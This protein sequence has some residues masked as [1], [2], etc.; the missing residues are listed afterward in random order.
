MRLNITTDDV[1]ERDRFELWSGAVFSTLAIAARPLP[2][3]EGPFQARFSARSRGPLLNCAFDSDGFHATRQSREIAHRQWDSYRIYREAGAGVWFSIAGQEMLSA[4]G[5][6]LVAD[7]DALFEARPVDRYADESWLIPK[8]LLDPHLPAT[9]RPGLTRLSGRSGVEA[10]AAGYLLSLTRHWDSIAEAS[11]GPVADT[12][13][14]LIGIACGAAAADQPDAVQAGRLVEAKRHIDR[15]L[16][17]PDLSPASVAAGLG[18][19]VRT[20]HLLFEPT[21]ASF[22]RYV[23]RRRLEECRAA[24]LANPSRP[25]IDIAFAW[26]FSSL[27]AFYRAFQAAFGMPPGDLRAVS[28]DAHGA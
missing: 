10:L 28:R 9:G 8:A 25:V 5:D 4:T 22:A 15:H 26:G 18:I 12:L 27:S 19:S 20:L 14:R 17:D 2:D 21:G 6:L 7:A 24:L 23:L 1:P 16:A 11:M 3:A 13:A